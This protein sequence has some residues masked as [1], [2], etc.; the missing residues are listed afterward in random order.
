MTTATPIRQYK[1]VQSM[2][3][4]VAGTICEIAPG[5][6]TG[7][8]VAQLRAAGVRGVRVQCHGRR[9]YLVR[10]DAPLVTEQVAT[11]QPLDHERVTGSRRKG[12]E[13]PPPWWALLALIGLGVGG[14]M[15]LR[16]LA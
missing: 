11:E 15:L 14:V 2:S 6:D 8:I 4:R 1:R 7:V 16:W 13:Q 5:E 9:C 12:D 10:A 3:T